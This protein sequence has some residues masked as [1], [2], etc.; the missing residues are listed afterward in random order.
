MALQRMSNMKNRIFQE[1]NPGKNI[2]PALRRL[3]FRMI[4]S[5]E[6]ESIDDGVS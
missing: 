3:F 1:R 6:E 4:F 2:E 5:R